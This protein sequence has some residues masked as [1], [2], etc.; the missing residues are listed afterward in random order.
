MRAWR[1]TLGIAIGAIRTQASRS[2]LASIGIVVGIVTVVLVASVL[3]NL[4]NQVALLFRELGTENIFV[5]HLSGDRSTRPLPAT[6]RA[7]RRRCAR[8]ACR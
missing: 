4:R 3:A 8:S 5:F 1:D 6:S 2:L 7:W